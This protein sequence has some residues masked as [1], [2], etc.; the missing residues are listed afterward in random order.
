MLDPETAAV[1][2]S[3]GVDGPPC[4]GLGVAAG[5]VWTCSRIE[6]NAVQRI[7]PGSGDVEATVPVNKAYEQGHLSTGFG[8][9][10]VLL[11]DG[12]SVL[13]I[14]LDSDEP[15]EPIALPVAGVDVAISSDRVWVVSASTTRPSR[16]IP[17]EVLWSVGSAG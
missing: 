1:V 16:S 7:D 15:G 13:G 2:S 17:S 3:L 10:W 14:D 12:S 4:Q 8:R 6:S 11:G 9:V 5:G